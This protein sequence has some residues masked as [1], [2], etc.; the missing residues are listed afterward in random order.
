MAA[1]GPPLLDQPPHIKLRLGHYL[2]R[3][4][5]I[6]LVIDRTATD[7]AKVRFDHD[8]RIW[9]ASAQRGP[10][11]RTDYMRSGDYVLLYVWEDGRT[12]VYVPDPRTERGIA[13]LEVIRDGDAYPLP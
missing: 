9:L 5:G 10:A 11:G 7:L 2:S 6:G 4:R 8:A 12:T 1:D 13:E 3:A